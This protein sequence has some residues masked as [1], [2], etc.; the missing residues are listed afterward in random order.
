MHILVS[1]AMGVALL[2]FW[3]VGWWFARV[4]VF[5]MF[6]AIGFIAAA[7]A[8]NTTAHGADPNAF[9]LILIGLAGAALAWPVAGIPAYYW[10]W[11]LRQMLTVYR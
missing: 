4:L 1:L 3:L 7:A 6:A 5:L 10:R 9:G 2:Y 8:V 11:R